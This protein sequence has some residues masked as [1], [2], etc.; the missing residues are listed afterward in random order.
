MPRSLGERR[1][2]KRTV[3]LEPEPYINI[4]ALQIYGVLVVLVCSSL[5]GCA[6]NW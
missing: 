4:K 5:T 2:W 1:K 6:V 3:V